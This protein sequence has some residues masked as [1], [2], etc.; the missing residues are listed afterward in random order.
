MAIAKYSRKLWKPKAAAQL[1]TAMQMEGPEAWQRQLERYEAVLAAV[2]EA[3]QPVCID[4]LE[5][6]P[7][8]LV[9]SIEASTR[10]WIEAL[11]ATMP[12]EEKLE[13]H[14]VTA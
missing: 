1:L 3:A 9:G 6:D 13:K 7:R 11:T 12:R 14:A 4:I 8:G 5:I 2:A 10:G